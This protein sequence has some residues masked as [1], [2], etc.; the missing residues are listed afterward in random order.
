[1]KKDNKRLTCIDLFA[2]AGGFSLGMSQA[3]FNVVVA[4]ERDKDA[5]QTLRAKE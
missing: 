4:V 2:G 1:M 3:G 5:C